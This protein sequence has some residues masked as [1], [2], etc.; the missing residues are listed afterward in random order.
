MSQRI[1]PL[2]AAVLIAVGGGVVP[3]SAQ[4]HAP[5]A[6]S[7]QAASEAA[8]QGFLRAVADSNLDKMAELWGTSKGSAAATHQP[9]DYQ[10]RLVVVQAY[11]RGAD[12]R[13]LSGAPDQSSKDRRVLQVEMSRNG[14]DKIV[15]FT[16]SQSRKGWLVSAI[17]LDQL[18]GPGHQCGAADSTKSP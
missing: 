17:D 14:C 2:V 10:R 18:G 7:A 1:L 5:S 9:S 6:G 16:T 11:L 3:A 15:P 4:S 8:V 12:Y 13:I